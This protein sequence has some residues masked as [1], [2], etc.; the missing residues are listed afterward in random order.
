MILM[1]LTETRPPLVPVRACRV[2]DGSIWPVAG[3]IRTVPTWVSPLTFVKSPATRSL[4]P[5]SSARSL[6][7]L[8]KEKVCPFHSPVVTSKP[9]RPED[10]ISWPFLPFCTPVKLPPTYMV[11]PICSKAWTWI[12]PSLTEPLRL[13]VTPQD[14]GEANSEAVAFCFLAGVPPSPMARKLASVERSC[15]RT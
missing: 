3:S 14:I 15:G 13:P 2:H 12:L 4:P 6:T 10:A 11:E 5:G 7:W 8:L 1:D 9:A